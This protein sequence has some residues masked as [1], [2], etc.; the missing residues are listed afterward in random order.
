MN[1]LTKFNM[2]TLIKMIL[3]H[4]IRD[5]EGTSLEVTD[6]LPPQHGNQK[7]P[8]IFIQFG[9]ILEKERMF[10]QNMNKI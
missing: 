1:S 8:K 2:L 3:S 10:F 6:D 7:I 5:I 4:A 9:L